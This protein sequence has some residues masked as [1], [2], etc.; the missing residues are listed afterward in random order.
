MRPML[1]AKKNNSVFQNSTRHLCL[2]RA[3]GMTATREDAVSCGEI[4][5]DCPVRHWL[6]S[7]IYHRVSCTGLGVVTFRLLL[8]LV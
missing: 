7:C 1:D 2:L 5:L 6:S 8:A 3:N 4:G